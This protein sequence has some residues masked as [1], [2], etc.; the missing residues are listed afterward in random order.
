MAVADAGAVAG[1]G[2]ADC[3]LAQRWRTSSRRRHGGTAARRHGGTAA[4]RRGRRRHIRPG[5]GRGRA[6]PT[7]RVV[8]VSDRVAPLRSDGA[9]VAADQPLAGVLA[10]GRHGRCG[11][12]HTPSRPR[13]AAAA[14]GR[15]GPC[16]PP[17]KRARLVHGSPGPP[18]PGAISSPGPAR[19]R[20]TLHCKTICLT[21][22]VWPTR[23]LSA[24]TQRPNTLLTC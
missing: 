15:T 7:P 23:L 14:K 1:A 6:C 22:A 4:R 9:G 24:P 13:R 3:C 10:D 11:P 8:Q 21:M 20:I 16:G 17:T 12:S 18:T 19:T 5:C 2:R